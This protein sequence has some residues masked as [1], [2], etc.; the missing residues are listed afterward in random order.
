MVGK[1]DPVWQL[2]LAALAAPSMSLVVLSEFELANTGCGLEPGP[3]GFMGAAEKLA[4]LVS[5]EEGVAALVAVMH[6]R[7]R[8]TWWGTTPDS[9]LDKPLLHQT[10]S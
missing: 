9:L 2:M 7:M 5:W 3:M 8:T 1:P 10:N 4:Y 6:Q